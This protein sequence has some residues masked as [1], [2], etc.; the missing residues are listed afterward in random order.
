M[1]ILHKFS[2]SLTS[3]LAFLAL[4]LPA[5]ASGGGFQM[6]GPSAR[7]M[8]AGGATGALTGDP[9]AMYTNPALLSFLQG[10]MFSLGATVSVPDQRFYGV[11][12]S[13][14][15]TKMQAQVL[16]PPSI[17]LSYTSPGRRWS[18]LC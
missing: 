8:S 16:F 5:D 9:A 18:Q 14:A 4:I 7:A 12:P 1:K 13:G 10:P 6:M 2:H 11:S 15:E 3:A 17:C